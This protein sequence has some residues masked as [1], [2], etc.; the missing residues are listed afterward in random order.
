MVVFEDA[1]W[2]HDVQYNNLK[3]QSQ[4]FE[5]ICGNDVIFEVYCNYVTI[6][7]G[8]DSDNVDIMIQHDNF[9]HNIIS[10][11]NINNII[12]YKFTAMCW[13]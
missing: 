6:I 12:L 9:D 10:Y 7:S 1:S 11:I 2:W 5:N 4:L 3:S 8:Y 13:I